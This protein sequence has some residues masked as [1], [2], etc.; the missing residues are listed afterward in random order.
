M[1]SPARDEYSRR[2]RN[3]DPRA[4]RIVRDHAKTRPWRMTEDAQLIAARRLARNLS[5]LYRVAAPRV[6]F[7]RGPESLGSG[8]YYPLQ[9][10]IV[11]PK[12]ALV[13]L[14]HEYRHHLQNARHAGLGSRDTIEVDARAWSISLFRAACPRRFRHM[15]AAGRIM[16]VDPRPYQERAIREWEDRRD[17]AVAEYLAESGIGSA[18]FFDEDWQVANPRPTFGGAS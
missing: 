6:V 1:P 9:R 11:L 8:A 3:L 2:F 7:T 15:A 17:A 10:L 12:Y 13:G 4:V 5:G 16:Y 18:G 14:L